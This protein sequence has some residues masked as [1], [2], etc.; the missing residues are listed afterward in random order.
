MHMR[1]AIATSFSLA[2]GCACSAVD[3]ARPV[4]DVRPASG[5]EAA[6]DWT[7]GVWVGVRRDGAD[8]TESAMTMEVE[9]ILAGA[10]QIRHLEIQTSGGVYRG[11]A[12]QAFDPELGRWVRFYLN[13]SRRR[14]ARLEG[15]V[16]GDDSVWRSVTP[17][18]TRESRLVS[19][20]LGSDRWRRTM[21][22]S[23]DG[24]AT[25]RALWIDDLTRRAPAPLD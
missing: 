8:G 14:Y 23:D 20:R 1:A 7:L 24:T 6:L 22:I 12:T 15:E 17:G 11:F 5:P 13:R 10:G 3:Q 18:R 9:P 19:E 21:S 25:W 4:P 2:L 16:T